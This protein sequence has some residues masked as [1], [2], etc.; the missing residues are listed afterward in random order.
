MGEKSA[1]KETTWGNRVRKAK[2][3]PKSNLK[4]II[5]VGLPN[6]QISVHSSTLHQGALNNQGQV[7]SFAMFFSPDFIYKMKYVIHAALKEFYRRFI[8]C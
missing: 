1:E 4:S 5:E 8:K 2:G 3:C 6:S 7:Q